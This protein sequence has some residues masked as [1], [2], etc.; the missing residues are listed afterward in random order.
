VLVAGLR[1]GRSYTFIVH[2]E[3]GV[4]DQ[5]RDDKRPQRITVIT[6]PAGACLPLCHIS[7]VREPVFDH[8]ISG[9]GFIEYL[10]AAAINN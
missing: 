10:K 3:N 7:S 6:Q 1:P 4:S 5:S 8:T 9:S 2:A